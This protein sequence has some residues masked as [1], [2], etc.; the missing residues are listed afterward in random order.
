MDDVL[1]IAKF[2]EMESQRQRETTRA[3]GEAGM[4][5]LA[6]AEFLLG[7]KR[8]LGHRNRWPPYM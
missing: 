2:I 5:S 6:G 7:V 4:G 1:R 8:Q 3:G